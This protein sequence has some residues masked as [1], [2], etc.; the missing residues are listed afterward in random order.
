MI[1]PYSSQPLDKDEKLFKLFSGIAYRDYSYNMDDIIV[2][3]I[4]QHWASLRK[5][6]VISTE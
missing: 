5:F 3:G 1:R 2:S 4:N 6:L